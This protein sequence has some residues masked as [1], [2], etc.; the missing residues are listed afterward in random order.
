MSETEFINFF[1]SYSTDLND[2]IY[3]VTNI[4][5]EILMYIETFI[6]VINYKPGDQAKYKH[7]FF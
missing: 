6:L 4:S 3:A 2:S 1:G 7:S 5:V